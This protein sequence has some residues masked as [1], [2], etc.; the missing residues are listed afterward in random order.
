[1]R[2]SLHG[3]ARMQRAIERETT[4]IKFQKVST[5]ESTSPYY[6]K[7]P[8]LFHVSSQTIQFIGPNS[9]P[10]SK[11]FLQNW[12]QSLEI[13]VSIF[14]R[15]SSHTGRFCETGSQNRKLNFR[16]NPEIPINMNFYKQTPKYIV[17]FPSRPQHYLVTHIKLCIYFLL[18]H[19]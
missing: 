4:F 15:L 6:K 10:C 7:L 11:S 3:A 16:H 17:F 19:C 12:I 14:E 5:F 18:S 1:M 9:T 8:H 13:N 2:Q